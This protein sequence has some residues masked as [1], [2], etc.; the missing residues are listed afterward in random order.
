MPAKLK[1]PLILSIKSCLAQ[2]Q[3]NHSSQVIMVI[4]NRYSFIFITLA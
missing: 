3:I 2:Q 1:P 4:N